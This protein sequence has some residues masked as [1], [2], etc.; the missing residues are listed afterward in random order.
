VEEGGDC[1]RG[2]GIVGALYYWLSET[3][4]WRANVLILVTL[5]L[6]LLIA[7]FLRPHALNQAFVYAI[8][9][10]IGALIGGGIGY[11]Y[12]RVGGFKMR[13]GRRVQ[14]LEV[15]GG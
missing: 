15:F 11:S 5:S 8:A 13:V 1:W 10:S 12:E 6:P 4:D 2:W 7:G 9:V 3:M 14:F